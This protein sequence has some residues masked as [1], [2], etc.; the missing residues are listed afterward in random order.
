[1]EKFEAGN[2]A[3]AEHVQEWE[4]LTSD[5]EILKIVKGDSIEFN[6]TTPGKSTARKCNVSPETKTKMD[7]EIQL[8]LIKKII[9]RTAH[10]PDEYVSP[11]FPVMKAD[12]SLRIILNLKE[13]NKYV[14]YHHFKMDNIKAVLA[15]VT[16]GCY[17]ATID[18]KQAYHSVKIQEGYQKYLKFSWDAEL[19][20]FT[21]YPNGLG[22]CPRKFTKL[23]KVPMS[24]LRERGH[25]IIGYI[26]DFHMLGKDKRVCE[27]TLWAAVALLQKL[28]F[29][30]HP[31]KS[32]LDPSTRIIFLGFIIDSVSMTVSLTPEKKEKLVILINVVLAHS[33]VT[34]ETVASVIGKIVSSL[35][36]SLY[37]PLH[38]R[39]IEHEKNKAL[40]ESKGNYSAA[41]TLSSD[42][43]DELAW[44]VENMNTMNAPIL[45]PPITA[46]IST[47]ASGKN[48]WGANMVGSTPI[49]G[50]WDDDQMDMHINIKE[51]LAIFYALRS[52]VDLLR[53]HHVRVLC[54]NTTAVFVLNKM[55]TTRSMDCNRVNKKIWEY[56]KENQIFITCTYIPGKENVVADIESRR[57]YKQAEWMLNKDIFVRAQKVFKFDVNIDCFASRANAQLPTYS[58]RSRDPYA[59]HIDAFSYNWSNYNAYLFPPFSLINRVIQKIRIDRSVSLCVF[60]EWKTQGWWPNLQK[61]MVGEPLRIP[62]NPENL[63]LP[64]KKEEYHPLHKKLGLV[65]CLLSGKNTD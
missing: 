7:A 52:F 65:I 35:P 23:M 38:Y 61:M 18:L 10:E 27:D 55:G 16:R 19:F 58:S 62:P 12:D 6:E 37:G 21:C 17:M 5:P 9:V 8:M 39:V 1:M 2:V 36:A 43:R 51:M 33:K 54:D 22:P 53:G 32:Q 46:E 34:I 57:E 31:L 44:W 48:G 45:W 13:L 15:N 28:G 24:F 30:I 47:D 59:T 11:I 29:T 60:P 50:V 42:A 20:Q 49:G 26:D 64:N 63:I 41:M 14:E 25:F 3:K 4:K 40:K 56:C